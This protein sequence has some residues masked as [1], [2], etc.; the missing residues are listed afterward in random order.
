MAV[1]VTTDYIELLNKAVER[2]LAVSV[3]Y[4]LQH[5]K[6]EKLMSKT[7]PENILLDKTTYDAI[8]KIFRDIAITEMKHAADI[9]ERIYFLG[10]KATTKASKTVIG[11]CISEFAKLGV[12]AE[13]EAMTLYREIIVEAG[14]LGDWKTR[15]LF[16]RIYKEEEDHLFK[17]QEYTSFQDEKDE[18]S[19]VPMPEW[20][21]IYTSEYFAL[22]NK[23]VAAEITG[24][25]QYTNQHEKAALEQLR[26]KDTA[27]ETV[28]ESNKAEVISKL[29]KPIFMQE[30]DHLEKISERIY[31]LEGEVLTKPDPLP[32]IGENPAEFLALD[33]KL[34]SETISLYRKIIAKAHALGD[35]TTM[36]M[37]E[38][39][40]IQ[41]EE[42]FWTFDDYVK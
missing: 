21:N 17:F 26:K 11:D 30:M 29:L 4:I 18:A 3:Q 27:L 33:H 24:I 35:I 31:L 34:E 40:I 10:G 19:K 15:E 14:K 23:A 2:E 37:F 41:E 22:L 28:T 36:R 13:E 5:G 16:E 32:V 12:K 6:M 25:V 42:H 39:I 9:M 1:K 8:G 38:D 20:R 7:S